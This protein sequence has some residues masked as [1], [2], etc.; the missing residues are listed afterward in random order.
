MTAG[1]YFPVHCGL[2]VKQSNS[3]TSDEGLVVNERDRGDFA[4]R[5]ALDRVSPAL[6]GHH[7]GLWRSR[8]LLTVS[9]R[10]RQRGRGVGIFKPPLTNCAAVCLWLRHC[11]AL[12]VPC[13][14]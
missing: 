5:S 10:G 1:K 4:A 9:H 12:L 2:D 3:Y 11:A 13:K 7:L 8:A 14:V 6:G